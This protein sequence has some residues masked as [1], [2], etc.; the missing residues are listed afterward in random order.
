MNISFELFGLNHSQRCRKDNFLS[1]D[2]PHFS[3]RPTLMLFTSKRRTIWTVFTVG[4]GVDVFRLKE[5]LYPLFRLTIIPS[6]A[7]RTR[8]LMNEGSL[9]LK[10]AQAVQKSTLQVEETFKCQSCLQSK[11]GLRVTC[12]FCERNT[13]EGC[14]RQCVHC[15]GIFCSL[16]SIVK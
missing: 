8:E 4:T 6:L 5:G 11:C 2:P 13:C 1:M 3:L 16:C 12:V 15:T 10:K 14:S 7:A 9:R